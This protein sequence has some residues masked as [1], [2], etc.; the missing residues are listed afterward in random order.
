MS[1]TTLVSSSATRE[2]IFKLQHKIRPSLSPHNSAIKP[3]VISIRIEN[4]ASHLPFLSQTT[5]PQPAKPGVPLAA[6]LVFSF[7]RPP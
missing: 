1:T 6:P 4:P 3:V 2:E 7:A 5:P